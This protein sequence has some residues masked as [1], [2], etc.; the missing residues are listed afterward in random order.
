MWWR[1]AKHGY[2]REKEKCLNKTDK[3][4]AIKRFKEYKLHKAEKIEKRI[5]K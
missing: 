4:A 5:R 3:K 2:D 1:K